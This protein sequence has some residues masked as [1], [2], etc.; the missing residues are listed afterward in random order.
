MKLTFPTRV[1]I[2]RDAQERS[3]AE[4]FLIS[5][6][7]TFEVTTDLIITSLICTCVNNKLLFFGHST[8]I[9]LYVLCKHDVVCIACNVI[10][11]TR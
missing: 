7:L 11:Y 2:T 8:H 1:N 3:P 5:F 4:I 10:C 9:T 6:L